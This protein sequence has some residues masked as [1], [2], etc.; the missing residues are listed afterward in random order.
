MAHQIT[1]NSLPV[2]T[3]SVTFPDW[4]PRYATGAVVISDQHF[5]L[6]NPAWFTNA[7]S[8]GVAILVD[9]GYVTEEGAHLL[10]IITTLPTGNVS[11]TLP[12]W[13]PEYPT[14]KVFTA[15]PAPTLATGGTAGTTSYF[16]KVVARFSSG[17][18]ATGAEASITTGNATLSP[19]N[20]NTLSAYSV[21]GATG[22]DIYRGTAAGNENVKVNSTPVTTST[23]NDTGGGTSAVV[24]ASSY[25]YVTVTTDEF[26]KL[27]P[28]LFT[29]TNAWSEPIFVDAGPLATGA[30]ETV[31]VISNLPAGTSYVELPT[32]RVI[33]AGQSVVLSRED[34]SKMDPALFGSSNSF[35]KAVLVDGGTV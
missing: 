4:F 24:P 27:P 32:R 14:G 3:V 19:T 11:I 5:S 35:G 12:N 26:G 22:Y 7:N 25:S 30:A 31:S 15:A 23:Y 34:F 21:T 18:A 13:L 33:T 16:Y 6:L 29:V 2:G 10:G 9:D 17:Q 28:S 1:V 8:M 20:Y